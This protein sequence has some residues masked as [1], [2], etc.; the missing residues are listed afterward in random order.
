MDGILV[1]Q[2]ANNS[3]WCISDRTV[4]KYLPATMG[5]WD[6]RIHWDYRHGVW[7][8]GLG[9]GDGFECRVMFTVLDTN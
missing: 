2:A 8:L 5:E 9:M 1:Y 4:H 3:R 7:K 6:T